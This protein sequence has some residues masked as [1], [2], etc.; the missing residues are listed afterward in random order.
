MD[1]FLEGRFIHGSTY[2][3]VYTMMV[4]LVT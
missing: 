1:L 4:F 3:Q 2:T